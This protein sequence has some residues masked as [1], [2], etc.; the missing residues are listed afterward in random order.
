M[1]VLVTVQVTLIVSPEYGGVGGMVTMEDVIEQIV[2]DIEDEYDFDD[3]E[4]NIV[5]EKG[6]VYRV[7]ALTEIGDFNPAFGVRFND[8]EFDTIGG[9]ILKRFGRVPKRGEQ[10]GFDN[11]TFKVLRADSRR[12]HLLQVTKKVASKG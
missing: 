1:P 5:P 12:L 8:Q 6:G 4:D 3:V 2:G 11:L 10:I 7:K 9:L